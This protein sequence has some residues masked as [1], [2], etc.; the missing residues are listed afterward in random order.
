[1]PYIET[2]S[3]L[4]DSIADLLGIYGSHKEDEDTDPCPCRV[5]F[6]S[7]MTERIQASVRNE[8]L[9]TPLEIPL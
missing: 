4:A 7:T 3:E 2:P 8:N 9:L 5:C 1:M 6:V